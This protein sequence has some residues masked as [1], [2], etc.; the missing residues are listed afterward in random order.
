MADPEFPNWFPLRV[1][2]CV[3]RLEPG[4]VERGNTLSPEDDLAGEQEAAQFIETL[5]VP[6]CPKRCARLFPRMWAAQRTVDRSL[7]RPK[8]RIWNDLDRAEVLQVFLLMTWPNRGRQRW[9]EDRPG[10]FKFG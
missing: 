2:E 8:L 10:G 3:S 7:L 9:E 4:L 5:T 1:S 6:E